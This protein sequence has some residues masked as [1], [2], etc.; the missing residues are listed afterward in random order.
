MTQIAAL[1]ENGNA[2]LKIE[3]KTL[4]DLA[5]LTVTFDISQEQTHKIHGEV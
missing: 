3:D 5:S 2:R 1:P 4:L